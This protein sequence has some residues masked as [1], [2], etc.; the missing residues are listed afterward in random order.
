MGK[1][2]FNTGLEMELLQEYCLVA[3]DVFRQFPYPKV[4]S[5]QTAWLSLLAAEDITEAEELIREY[6]WLEKKNKEI[7]E[8]EQRTAKIEKEKL[9]AEKEKEEAEKLA[10][11]QKRQLE[12]L[13]QE[14]EAQISEL[15]SLLKEKQQDL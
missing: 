5:E 4:R 9:Q 10:E 14:K 8:Y 15:V 12:T 11:I 6:P 2:V 3:L 13:L 1:T 7:T